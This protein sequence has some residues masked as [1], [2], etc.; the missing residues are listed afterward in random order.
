MHI[1]R[2]GAC[3]RIVL[4][5]NRLGGFYPASQAIA[6]CEAAGIGVSVD[7]NPYSII[8]DTAS[9]H[10]AA[11]VR[12]AYPVDCEGHVS[13]LDFGNK[14]FSGGI[15]FNEGRARL[16]TAA[17]LGVDV[18]WDQLADISRPQGK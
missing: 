13:F 5:L 11:T 18:N 9:C 6:V 8:G 1:V 2:V 12:T 16:P 14:A 10:I 3:D 7:T 17:G 4:K 15:T